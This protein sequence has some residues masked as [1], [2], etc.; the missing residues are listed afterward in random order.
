[1]DSSVSYD[2]Q[3]W[4]VVEHYFEPWGS[5]NIGTFIGQLDDYQ[6][7]KKHWASLDYNNNLI[8]RKISSSYISEIY[9]NCQAIRTKTMSK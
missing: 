2:V 8:T 9:L 3:C 4:F 1:M 5:K 7:Q 6:L